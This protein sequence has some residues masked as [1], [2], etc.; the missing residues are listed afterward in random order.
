MSI[1]EMLTHMLRHASDPEEIVRIIQSGRNSKESSRE[2]DEYLIGDNLR[3]R[4]GLHQAEQSLQELS[5]LVEIYAAPPWHVATFLGLEGNGSGQPRAVVH[6]GNARRVVGLTEEV[7]VDTLMPGDHVLLGTDPNV[8]I[9]KSSVGIPKYGDT[10]IF[11]RFTAGGRLVVRDRDQEIV[12]EAGGAVR[13]SHLEAGDRIR[14]DRAV[15]MAY[16]KLERNEGQQYVID[17]I[18]TVRR[19]EVGGQEENIETLLS[20]LTEA[21]MAPEEAK[22]YGL[23]GRL[24]ISL[25]GRPGTGKTLLARLSASEI[26][27]ISGKPCRFAVVKPGEWQSPWVGETEANIRNCFKTLRE[28]SGE[29]YVVLFMDEIES[30]GRIRGSHMGN[31]HGDRFLASLLAELDGFAS[32]RTN[33]LAVISATNRKDLLD[34]ALYERL[35]DVEI[36]VSQPDLKGA[37]AIFEIH[38]PDSLPYRSN[39]S[40]P[41]ATRFEMIER[42]VSRFYSPNADNR[43]CELLFRDGA[44]RTVGAR[45]LASGRIFEQICLSA[46]RTAFHRKIVNGHDEGLGLE[47]IEKA[48]ADGIDRLRTTLTPQNV[49]AYLPD[50]PES[51]DVIEV[52]PIDRKV[53]QPFT[54]TVVD[55]ASN[56]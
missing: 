52:R 22:V 34:P 6:Y 2:L 30:I 43:L 39:G 13:D 7:A 29:G 26:T 32:P 48:L 17:E 25:I 45:E 5:K 42:A 40:S 27:R 11:D 38:L 8:I 28:T 9:Q 18:P 37:R 56:E 4:Q 54:Y 51:V 55:M 33:N 12:L 20:A 3:L 21:L 24:T 31:Y 44:T 47:D 46:R 19:E 53:N 1:I 35:S 41:E 16:E 15:Y 36:H 14:F 49:H 23:G 10:A 50:I